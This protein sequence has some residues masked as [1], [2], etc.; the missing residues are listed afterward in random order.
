MKRQFDTDL[1]DL[2]GRLLRMGSL[3]EEM[4]QYARLTWALSMAASSALTEA[5]S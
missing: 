5:V 1:D 2:R 4:V 3:C